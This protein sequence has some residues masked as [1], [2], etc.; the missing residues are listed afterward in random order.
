MAESLLLLSRPNL[1]SSP[2]PVLLHQLWD[3]L[4]L[5]FQLSYEYTVGSE[6]SIDSADANR[7][8]KCF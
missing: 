3:K 1:G 5:E 6:F 2:A 4:W 7:C 8:P